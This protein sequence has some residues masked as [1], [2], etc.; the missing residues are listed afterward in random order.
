MKEKKKIWGN[1]ISNEILK[2]DNN[3][4]IMIFFEHKN[5]F[6]MQKKRL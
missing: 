5:G 3:K 6:F 2:N 4:K 1:E